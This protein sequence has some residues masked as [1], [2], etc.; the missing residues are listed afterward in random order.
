VADRVAPLPSAERSERADGVA[1]PKTARNADAAAKATSAESGDSALALDQ[2]RGSAGD[3]RG[4]PVVPFFIG[5][6]Y[7]VVELVSDATD[8]VGPLDVLERR[9]ERVDDRRRDVDHVDRVGGGAAVVLDAAEAGRSSE[10]LARC[11]ASRFFASTA[12]PILCASEESSATSL[13]T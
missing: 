2:R 4:D 6:L 9:R 1:K 8:E 11:R 5:G 12:R 3:L 13:L 7:Q 10:S